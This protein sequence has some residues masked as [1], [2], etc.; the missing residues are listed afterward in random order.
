MAIEFVTPSP[1]QKKAEDFWKQSVL[2]CLQAGAPIQ[3]AIK[4]SDTAVMAFNG[5]FELPLQ[6]DVVY[7]GHSIEVEATRRTIDDLKGLE[8]VTQA[9][10]DWVYGTVK[11]YSYAGGKQRED[12]VFVL[13]DKNDA[14]GNPVETDWE[15]ASCVFMARRSPAPAQEA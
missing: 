13:W 12:M 15:T 6:P 8:V 3:N 1:H 2:A 14:D 11:D 9:D 4:A 10:G 5:R 7:A